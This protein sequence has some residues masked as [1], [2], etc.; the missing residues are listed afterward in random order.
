MLTATIKLWCKFKKKLREKMIFKN[1]NRNKGL[2]HTI[3]I[4][5]KC[6][7]RSLRKLFK[8]K[9]CWEIFLIRVFI[10]AV[11]IPWVSWLYSAL[12]LLYW[13]RGNAIVASGH[14]TSLTLRQIHLAQRSS[15]EGPSLP[16][17]VPTEDPCEGKRGVPDL[18]PPVPREE[19]SNRRSP[20]CP[21]SKGKLAGTSLKMP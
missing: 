2:T 10:I 5:K 9:I 17:P 8:R 3:K 16:L 4:S 6:G 11:L 13:S 7:L 12:Y 20:S 15:P 18:R 21:V 19:L 14:K 1:L